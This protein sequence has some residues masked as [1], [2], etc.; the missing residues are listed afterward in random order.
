MI[1]DGVRRPWA[2]VQ[3]LKE[4]TIT[5]TLPIHMAGSLCMIFLLQKRSMISFKIK[6]KTWSL[7]WSCE[8]KQSPSSHFCS[9][10]VIL[11]MISPHTIFTHPS[12][13]L[14]VWEITEAWLTCK[15]SLY[16][17][18]YLANANDLKSPSS[19][20]WEFHQL[21]KLFWILLLHNKLRTPKLAV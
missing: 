7:L 16:Q 1:R 21:Q 4:F 2:K 14:V 11:F 20:K 5:K 17:S 3:L 18:Q 19:L 9:T 15:V 13:S 8:L 6:F 12:S 10:L